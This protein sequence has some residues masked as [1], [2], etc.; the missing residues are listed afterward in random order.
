MS[1]IFVVTISA[2]YLTYLVKNGNID[3]SKYVV[4]ETVASY[5]KTTWLDYYLHALSV[6]ANAYMMCLTWLVHF[7]YCR[8]RAKLSFDTSKSLLSLI[9]TEFIVSVAHQMRF[10]AHFVL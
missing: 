4:L 9:C 3:S 5:H 10:L 7:T 8:G 2:H 1:T 6:P